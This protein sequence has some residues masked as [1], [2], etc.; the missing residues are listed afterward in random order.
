[1]LKES[2]EDKPDFG[3]FIMDGHNFIILLVDDDLR[4]LK[5][6][7]SILKREGYTPISASEG[8][9]GREMARSQQPDLILLDVMMPQ[10]SGFETCE[11]LKQDPLTADIPIIF[12][13]ALDDV[14][15]KVTGLRSGGVDYISKP[16]QREEVL[17]RVKTHLKLRLAYHAVI[18][19][20]AHRLQSI[21]QAQ[22]DILV[23]PQD[24]PEACFGLYYRPIQEAGGDFYDV[25]NIYNQAYGY[26]IAD[27]SGHDVGAAFVTGILKPLVRQN[28]NQLN[29]PVEAL[30]IINKVLC[31]ILNSGR[32]LTASYLFLDRKRKE[33]TIISAGH[34]PGLY[35]K[36]SKDIEVLDLRGDVLGMFESA[37]FESKT[38][39]VQEGERIFLY[40]DG[41]LE[42]FQR[43]I[44]SKERAMQTLQQECAATMD[45]DVQDAVNTLMKK[46]DVAAGKPADDHLL[47]A[48]DV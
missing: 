34:P 42:E 22:Q 20:Q 30:K 4:N 19:E 8:K 5:L 18:E 1:M 6:L 21:Q 7:E 39:K 10:E 13:S 43:R 47:L 41:I 23:D 15:N 2:V 38:F 31:S 24:L 35:I 17:A 48:V 11:K 28:F 37:F 32:F 25:F 46:M 16:F 27:I 44:G 33:L 9:R 45:L 40:S 36:S 3:S 12:I 14:Q 29:T 26:F